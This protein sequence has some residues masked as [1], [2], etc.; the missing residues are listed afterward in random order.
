MS[1]APAA[2]DLTDV[3]DDDYTQEIESY[4]HFVSIFID[5]IFA[6]HLLET[7][8]IRQKTWDRLTDP[9]SHPSPTAYHFIKKLLEYYLDR[10]DLT[11]S[12]DNSL[13]LENPIT[14][15]DPGDEKL[16]DYLRLNPDK[17]NFFGILRNIRDV[18]GEV[19]FKGEDA[20]LTMANDDFRQAMKLWE[21]LMVNAQVKR[22]CHQLVFRLLKKM[23]HRKNALIVFEGGAGVGAI[24]R[25]GLSDAEFADCL[26]R[27]ER[28]TFTDISLSLIKMG[29]ECLR[30]K[31]PAELFDRFTF[32]VV[33]LD[34]MEID[35]T[36]FT[37]AES[38]D[39]II[40][41]HVLYDV[42]D[43]HRTLETFRHMLK[44]DGVLVFT[45]AYRTRPKDFFPFEYLQSSF[46]SY[47]Q[48]KLESGFR[49]NIGYLTLDEWEA[50]LQ[51][52]GFTRYEVHPAAEDQGKWPYGGIVAYPSK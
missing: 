47:N 36:P 24:L 21:D 12:A 52:A 48:A 29:R 37:Q 18:I 26:H 46:Q 22:P 30:E 11:V 17:K 42:V 23:K 15:R 13:V 6:R 5:Q 41:E 34:K 20:L 35:Q 2:I 8:L 45:M 38:T 31:L 16:N 50:S 40:L 25:D 7:G 14:D 10:G 4:R 27:V 39:L 3:Y 43:L 28:Y 44:P 1:N 51:R 49:E 33:N 19:L 32:K 9:E